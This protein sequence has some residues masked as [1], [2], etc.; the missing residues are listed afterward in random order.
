VRQ[1]TA[2]P[3]RP[4]VFTETCHGGSFGSVS[5]AALVTVVE[6]AWLRHG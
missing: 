4:S 6:L 2:A 5:R 1:G 3:A